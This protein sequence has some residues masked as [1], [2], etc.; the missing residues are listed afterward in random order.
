MEDQSYK[1]AIRRNDISAPLKWLEKHWIAEYGLEGSIKDA[2]RKMGNRILD[3]GSGRGED[4]TYLGAE[5]YDPFYY[6]FEP[7]G[8][9]EIILCT[10]VLNVVDREERA[11]ILTKLD[12][13]AAPGC[14]RYVTV[15]RD[16][17]IL[18]SP[19]EREGYKQWYVLTGDM[20]KAGY[21]SVYL[22]KNGFEIYVK[23]DYGDY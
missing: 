17:S 19:I 20:R 21:Q 18:D 15:R 13:L 1:S 6:P 22:R 4:A 23:S 14:V 16:I 11:K 8:K 7:E 9:F 5:E 3:Y 12:E 2:A 10:Y